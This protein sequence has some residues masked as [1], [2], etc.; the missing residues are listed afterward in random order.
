[1]I[2]WQRISLMMIVDAALINAAL[3]L[4]M[5]LRFDG[6]I[7]EPFIHSMLIMVPLITLSNLAFL[8]AFKLYDRVWKYASWGE[9]FSIIKASVC[10]ILVII[11]VILVFQLP[12]LPRSVYIMT[13]GLIV[14]FIAVSRLWW[15]WYKDMSQRNKQREIPV[16]IVGAGD[17]GATIV[18]EIR[19]NPMLG[20]EPVAF[21]D[22]DPQKAGKM[23]LGLRIMGNRYDIPEL[24]KNLGIEEIIIAIPSIIGPGLR[25]IIKICK[26]T[27]ASLKI[28]PPF[29]KDSQD[30]LMAHVR[31]VNMDDLLG[32]NPV[33]MDMAKICGYIENKTI[34]V[35]GGGGSIGSEICRQ[36]CGLNPELLV[37]LDN[38]ENNLFD[39]EMELRDSGYVN[40]IAVVLIDVKHGYNVEE[41]FE[42]YRPQ[43][44]FHAA[45][46]KHVPMVERYPEEAMWN[47]V[48]GSL[49]V[50]EMAD[51]FGSETFILI[52][53]DKAVNPTSI[54]GATK[55]LAELVI[56]DFNQGSKTRFAVVRFGN[57]L[58][59]RGSVIPTFEK[60][61]E[62]GGPVTV[63][64]PE[65]KRYFMTI[66]EAVGLVI[67]AGA[68]ARGGE[69]FVLD[70]GEPVRI[71]DLAH[72]LIKLYGYK[73]GEDIE[74]V[75]TGIRPGEKLCE[76]LFYQQEDLA[77]TEHERIF[78]SSKEVSNMYV[79][80]HK[81]IVG[82]IKNA[83]SSR[84]TIIELISA[85]VPEY[86]NPDYIK[87]VKAEKEKL[88]YL[89]EK[90]QKSG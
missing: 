82:E 53:T 58:G 72:D 26:E 28:I 24:V 47:N 18:R 61:I 45:A 43:V 34:L 6:S 84:D 40:K 48:V 60:Q 80:I 15:R 77:H 17:A 38:S 27:S 46:Y 37:I 10:S 73:P 59:S 78:I 49:N 35:T 8:L 30:N 69:T 13:W 25:G 20:L 14:V 32:R 7:P 5:L 65:M 16:L 21:V 90:R 39:I 87:T 4:A 54:M 3:V 2:N 79:G 42:K 62:R 23:M 50:A 57:V 81:R 9:L 74:I 52:S 75:Y 67:Q 63:T 33:Q 56:R 85:R 44:I 31:R 88:V 1:M 55:R 76:E 36:V 29:L 51:K 66:P 41:V 64:H 68:I 89:E 71:V 70:M 22:D 19:A 83:G 11:T 86:Y 12:L